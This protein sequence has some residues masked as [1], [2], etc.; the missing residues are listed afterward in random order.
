MSELIIKY[1]LMLFIVLMGALD[2]SGAAKGFA[3]GKYFIAGI[4]C[5]MAIW[6]ICL[7]VKVSFE[8]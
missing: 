5:M 8:I 7:I 2:I 6:M 1:I 4:D 3:E